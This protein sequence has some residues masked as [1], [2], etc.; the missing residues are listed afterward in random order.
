MQILYNDGYVSGDLMDQDRAD[1]DAGLAAAQAEFNAALAP[2]AIKLEWRS[3]LTLQ[4]LHEYVAAEARSADLVITC[5]TEAG[6]FHLPTRHADTGDLVMQ[7]GRPVLV[8]SPRAERL[9]LEQVI[10]GWKDTREARRAVAN[11]LPLLL[12]ASRVTVV[13]ISADAEPADKRVGEVALWLQRHGV[14]A[15]PM[16]ARP[17]SDDRSGL[18]AVAREQGADL[19]VAGA[20]GHS[21]LREWVLG[22][23]TR[24]LLKRPDG[25]VLLS[26]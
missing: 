24:D 8:A 26:H 16:T 18:R 1:I 3:A 19:I 11:A 25:C 4:P 17:C 13:E 6:S 12:R 5:A 22:G 2:R 14:N 21:R 9:Q 7:A 23:V 20:Y 15:A 10:V